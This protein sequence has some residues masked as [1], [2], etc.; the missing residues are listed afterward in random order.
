MVNPKKQNSRS[1]HSDWTSQITPIAPQ[2]DTLDQSSISSRTGM[3]VKASLSSTHHQ[4]QTNCNSSHG[5]SNYTTGA[6][7]LHP[8]STKPQLHPQPPIPSVSMSSY[9]SSAYDR[10]PSAEMNS[11]PYSQYQQ[12]SSSRS[13]PQYSEPNYLT[14]SKP[15]YYPQQQQHGYAAGSQPF[16]GTGNVPHGGS[17]VFCNSSINGNPSSQFYN[18]PN[19]SAAYSGH[20]PHY[21]QHSRGN[22]TGG[23]TG[24]S[25][26]SR[27][28]SAAPVQIPQFHE[29]S[30]QAIYGTAPYHSRESP[31]QPPGPHHAGSSHT[32]GRLPFMHQ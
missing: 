23:Y 7:V 13:G 3:T 20:Q 31:S 32:S 30:S 14:V 27:S 2:L 28:V 9:S 21:L 12:Q 5:I 4:Y 26:F 16:S 6:P 11:Q 1:K 19:Q 25:N 29:S 24:T 17:P 15:G 8:S 18:P 22:S 10:L